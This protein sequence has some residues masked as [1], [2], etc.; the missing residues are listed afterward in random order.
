MLDRTVFFTI[1]RG[2]ANNFLIFF[3]I[4]SSGL[5]VSPEGV[6]NSL[7]AASGSSL[8]DDGYKIC[9]R[10]A[11]GRLHSIRSIFHLLINYMNNPDTGGCRD[12]YV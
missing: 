5:N 6:L 12:Y 3:K 9:S 11:I 8:T 2:E 4:F 1:K 10:G 7:E